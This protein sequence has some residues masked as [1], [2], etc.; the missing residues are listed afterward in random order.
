MEERQEHLSFM[1]MKLQSSFEYFGNQSRTS[2]FLLLGLTQD[3]KLQVLLFYAFFIMYL[4]TIIANIGI[5]LIIQFSSHLHTPMYFFLGNLSFID[6]CYSSS[7]VPNTMV[8]LLN[9]GKCITSI[10]CAVQ[11]FMFCSFGSTECLLFGVMAYDR[12]AAICRPLHY[13][14]MMTKQTYSTLMAVAYSAAV[15][16]AII[17]ISSIFTL[18][19]C[20]P[21]IIN[22]FICDAL[23]L[24]RLS[25]SDI[26]LNEMLIIFCAAVIGGGPLFV[27][28]LS[29]IYIVSTVLKIPSSQGKRRAFSTCA[30]HLTCVTLFY[31]TVLFNYLHTAGTSSS[32]GQEMAASVFYIVVIP[33]L[34]PLIY[35][36]RNKEVKLILQRF[37]G[38]SLLLG[39]ILPV[40]IK[41]I[42]RCKGNKKYISILLL[43]VRLPCVSVRDKSQ[44]GVTLQDIGDTPTNSQLVPSDSYA[45]RNNPTSFY[46]TAKVL[47]REHFGAVVTYL[48]EHVCLVIVLLES[49][50]LAQSEVLSALDQ[51]LIK[52]I[53]AFCCVQRKPA[54]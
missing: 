23:P 5:C 52:D 47:E 30:S 8:Q 19:F 21:N 24:I 45:S 20:G 26:F 38:Q 11:L 44:A 40:Q 39:S 51:V 18:N 43:Y 12:Y 27:I 29:Y 10:G 6:L 17:Q 36:I 42:A 35:S 53:Y 49:E 2:V 22:H 3:P 32:V 54:T 46:D 34:N 13:G 15:L 1:Q 41:Y 25:C 14:V 7:V 31:G 16:H 48:M 28:I 37:F 9:P 33:M 50:P 4:I